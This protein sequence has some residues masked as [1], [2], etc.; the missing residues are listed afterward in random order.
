MHIFLE[1][2]RILLRQFILADVDNLLALDRDVEVRR[3]LDMPAPPTRE[4]IAEHTLPRFM[5]Y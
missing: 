2:E 1:T 5:A 3:Y 4:S